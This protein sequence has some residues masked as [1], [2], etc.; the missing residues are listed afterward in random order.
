MSERR[1]RIDVAGLTKAF[2]PVKKVNQ[3]SFTVEPASITAFLG[4]NSGQ[5][6]SSVRHAGGTT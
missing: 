5:G 1:G 3:L 6:L 4:P 2:G